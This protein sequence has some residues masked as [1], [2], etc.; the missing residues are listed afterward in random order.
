MFDSKEKLEV[1]QGELAVIEA[2]LHTQIKILNVQANAGGSGARRKLNEVKGVLAQ[3]AALKKGD[4]ATQ[5]SGALGWLGWA[6]ASS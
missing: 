5:G 2:A 6:R 1:S 3:I 4:D